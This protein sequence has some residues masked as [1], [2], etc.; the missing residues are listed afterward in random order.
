VYPQ[1]T[2][3]PRCL[4]EFDAPAAVVFV[5][6]IIV[7]DTGNRRVQLFSRDGVF[8][9]KLVN[10][11]AR[12]WLRKPGTLTVDAQRNLHIAGNGARRIRVSTALDEAALCFSAAVPLLSDWHA[13]SGGNRPGSAALRVPRAVAEH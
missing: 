9:D 7:S 6:R 10:P 11:K 8:L 5:D 3:S 13:S 4:A 1:S 2:Q 12:E